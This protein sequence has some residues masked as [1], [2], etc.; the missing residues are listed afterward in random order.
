MLN[1][2]QNSHFSASKFVNP[3]LIRGG[4]INPYKIR[5]YRLFNILKEYEKASINY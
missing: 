2:L 3:K 1:I 4:A 5:D